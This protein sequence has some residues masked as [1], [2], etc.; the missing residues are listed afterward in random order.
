MMDLTLDEQRAIVAQRQESVRQ[1]LLAARL[2]QTLARIGRLTNAVTDK[3]V[4]K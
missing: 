2:A 3:E 4:T 1:T